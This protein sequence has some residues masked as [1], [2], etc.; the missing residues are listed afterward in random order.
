VKKN[1]ILFIFLCCVSE[2][3]IA[4][5][6]NDAGTWLTFTI[7][8]ALTKKIILVVDEE[9]RLKENYQRIN[10]FYTNIGV[11]Y[12]IIKNLKISP[13]YRFIQKKQL[14]GYYSFRHRFQLD[15]T[16]KKKFNKITLS[17]RVRYQAEVSDY[18]TSEKGRL[19]EQFLRFKTDFKYGITEKIT[20]YIS[21][22]MRYQIRAPRGDGPL[23]NNGFHRVRSVIG[24]E[25]ELN[26]K[27][28]I[29]L[30]Y[31]YQTEFTISSPET[32]FILG[33]A[34]TLTI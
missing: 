1:L 30:Y 34:Y 16:G 33:V 32:I 2:H 11:D 29:N 31:L 27:Q 17:E 6:S 21:V 25:Y 8:H 18:L 3:S 13:T 14:E 4:Q 15:V 20:P 9:L 10:L 26:K 24:A 7:Q 12:K 28:S 5:Q 19:V 23:Y 22:E